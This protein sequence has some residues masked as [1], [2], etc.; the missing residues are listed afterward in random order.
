MKLRETWTQRK[1]Y[2]DQLYDQQVF[3]RDANTLEQLSNTQEVSN[4][5]GTAHVCNE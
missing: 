2:L 5:D 4:I 1:A 3:Y